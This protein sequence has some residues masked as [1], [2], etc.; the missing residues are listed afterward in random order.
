MNLFMFDVHGGLRCLGKRES[1]EQPLHSATRRIGSLQTRMAV[2]IAP[3]WI[4]GL[5]SLQ[6]IALE[7]F[8]FYAVY[9][10]SFF[11]LAYSFATFKPVEWFITVVTSL[12]VVKGRSLLTHPA[13]KKAFATC[14]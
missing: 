9:E 6:E 3:L 5:I 2:A 10:S 13:R 1:L 8:E 11:D 12:A 4:S 14:S 7:D